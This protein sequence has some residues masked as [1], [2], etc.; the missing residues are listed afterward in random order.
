MMTRFYTA[1]TSNI[2]R[3]IQVKSALTGSANITFTL[4]LPASS[5]SWQIFDG[6]YKIIDSSNF[7]GRAVQLDGIKPRRCSK[8]PIVSALL[9]NV[10]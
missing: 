8:F 10:L 6:K 1:F 5:Y 9:T 2:R 4:A 3:Y 7:R